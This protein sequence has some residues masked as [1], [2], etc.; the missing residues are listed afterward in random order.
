[1]ASAVLIGTFFFSEFHISWTESYHGLKRKFANFSTFMT[2]LSDDESESIIM[3][4]RAQKK[5]YA[6]I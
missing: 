1:M 3:K 6:M 2:I 4:V 5:A